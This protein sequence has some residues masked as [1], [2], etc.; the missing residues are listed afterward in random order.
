VSSGA[1]TARHSIRGGEIPDYRQDDQGAAAALGRAGGADAVLPAANSGK[2]LT[3]M[4][5]LAGTRSGERASGST[6]AV[7]SVLR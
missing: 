5:W 1:G 6:G 7:L 3:Q 2:A 4:P